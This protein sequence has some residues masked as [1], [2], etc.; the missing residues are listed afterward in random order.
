MSTLG[1]VGM[2]V[3]ISSIRLHGLN[4]V[5]SVNAKRICLIVIINSLN[6]LD[7]TRQQED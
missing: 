4:S 1:I 6:P 3:T 2:H 5:L 7:R